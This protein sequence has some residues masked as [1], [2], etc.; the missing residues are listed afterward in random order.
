[1]SGMS[2]APIHPLLLRAQRDISVT[3][4]VICL[5]ISLVICSFA[6]STFA[7]D[8]CGDPQVSV[9][10]N[11][12]I[13]VLD[14]SNFSNFI[15][16]HRWSQQAQIRD[17]SDIAQSLMDTGGARL[18]D[19]SPFLDFLADYHSTMMNQSSE[20]I[21]RAL[22]DEMLAQLDRLY[23]QHKVPLRRIQFIR[24]T[25]SNPSDY[26]LF[27]RYDYLGGKT[28][29]LSMRV[30][31][32]ATMEQRVFSG[33]GPGLS[34]AKRVAKQIFDA[35]QLADNDTAFNPLANRTFIA[36][37]GSQSA[38]TISAIDATRFCEALGARLPTR[39]EMKLAE[40]V[41][42]YVSGIQLL[43]QKPYFVLDN[44]RLSTLTLAADECLPVPD[45]RQ[46]KA[47]LVCVQ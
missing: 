29:R 19:V 14:T 6:S 40:W 43:P 34:A 10:L 37:D 32:L 5:V 1:M 3:C 21:G 35:F 30:V 25:E 9:T 42:P 11:A 18:S 13:P 46:T 38:K 23:F 7:D 24:A 31:N 44:G 12:Q 20:S 15:S 27:G 45:I 16:A 41:G 8:F 36:T 47:I 4:L 26:A 33:S 22:S 39:T 2:H 17:L 28:I